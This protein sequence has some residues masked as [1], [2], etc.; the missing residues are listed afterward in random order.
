MIL[1]ISHLALVVQDFPRSL[2]FYEELLGFREV[3]DWPDK[4]GRPW[5]KMLKVAPGQFIEL[6]IDPQRQRP[7][8]N[9]QH[10]CLEVDDIHAV[11]ARLRGAGLVLDEEP[12]E[13]G[14]KNWQCWVKDPDGHRIEFMQMHPESLH[15]K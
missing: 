9:D 7:V 11:A 2:K 4:Q 10:F 6:F 13:G 3:A 14:Q 5:I 15:K 8:H 12:T 1:G